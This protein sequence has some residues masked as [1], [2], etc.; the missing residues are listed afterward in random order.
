MCRTA[1]ECEIRCV[2][3]I[4]HLTILPSSTFWGVTTNSL[5]ISWLFG[6]CQKAYQGARKENNW[7][8]MDGMKMNLVWRSGLNLSV[9]YVVS[10]TSKSEMGPLSTTV[11]HESN[12]PSLSTAPIR[13]QHQ[14][15]EWSPYMRYSDN[16]IFASNVST[17]RGLS[18]NQSSRGKTWVEV[19]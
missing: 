9:L 3:A 18:H 1:S 5:L 2:N 17:M 13:S 16:N 8:E 6:E 4:S 19:L 10:V 12:E 15:V 14:N 11:N 7:L